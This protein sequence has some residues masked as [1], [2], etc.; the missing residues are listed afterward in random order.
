MIQQ[1]YLRE[2]KSTLGYFGTWLP[3]R[4]M[5]LGDVGVLQKGDFRYITTLSNLNIG[6][7]RKWGAR[8]SD[9][10]AMSTSGISFDTGVSLSIPLAGV[11]IGRSSP[12]ISI[13]FADKGGFVFQARACSEQMINNQ[14]RLAEDLLN[15]LR[16]ELWQPEWVVVDTVVQAQCSTVVVSGS[17]GAQLDLAVPTE[18]A[19]ATL[20]LANVGVSVAFQTGQ[21]VRV[22][23]KQ[24]STPLYRATRIRRRF[25]NLF[26]KPMVQHL[27]ED[28]TKPDPKDVLQ[29]VDID[30]LLEGIEE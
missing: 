12:S 29:S 10:E 8:G 23:A 3:D 19:T 6:F 7:D 11:A 17:S 27:G 28:D 13:R 2:I 16:R 21:F 22:V 1:H 9:I 25:W 20:P 26:G 15:A 30:E 14:S 4:Q 5:R 24:T 18:V